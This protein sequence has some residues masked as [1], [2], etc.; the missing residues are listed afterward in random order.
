MAINER[1]TGDF[2]K[3]LNKTY[4]GSWDIPEHED[5]IVTIDHC[6]EQII[7]TERGEST[8]VVA[9]FKD[10]KPMI[11]NKT[12]QNAIAT[13]LKSKKFEEWENRKIAL[14][15]N[16]NVAAF[17]K[18]VEAV[19]VREFAPRVTEL[20]CADCKRVITDQGGYKARTIA[21]RARTKYGV[22]LCLECG[23]FRAQ[24][25]AVNAEA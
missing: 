11:L 14:Y 7:K 5:L 17:G 13:A 12:N 15:V 20:I 6:E 3:H 10:A 19:R 1:L 23:K 4:L 24:A 8:E 22:Y 25:D 18:T 16:P 2:R 9:I 21:E